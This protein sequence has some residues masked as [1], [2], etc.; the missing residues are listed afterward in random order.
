MD[1]FI[2]KGKEI[3]MLRCVNEE[4]LHLE[5]YYFEY[6][7]ESQIYRVKSLCK[8]KEVYKKFLPSTSV[9]ILQN[10]EKKLQL[11]NKR[12]SHLPAALLANRLVV[13][14]DS[15]SGYISDY[16]NW[17]NLEDEIVYS[18]IPLNKKIETLRKVQ[19]LL[20][21][22]LKE[23]I[24][25]LDPSVANILCNLNKKKNIVILDMDNIATEEYPADIYNLRMKRYLENGG[26]VNKQALIFAVNNLTRSCLRREFEDL[27]CSLSIKSISRLDYNSSIMGNFCF[28]LDSG[29]N[30]CAMDHEFL[31]DYIENSNVYQRKKL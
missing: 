14:E 9:K 10:K 15:L 26:K 21:E 5:Y 11:L 22:Y 8:C 1:V 4:D 19:N 31:L 18:S 2:L 12:S 30:D 7:S 24:Y 13:K 17:G 28:C 3:K 23:G 27:K 6:G 20:V 25:Y 16:I 29:E